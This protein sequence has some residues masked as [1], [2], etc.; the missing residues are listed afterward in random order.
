MSPRLCFP[1]LYVTVIFH[2]SWPSLKRKNTEQSSQTNVFPFIISRPSCKVFF[3][4]DPIKIV[5]AQGQ[6]MFDERGEQYLDCINNVAH[7]TCPVFVVPWRIRLWS[8]ADRAPL[9]FVPGIANGCSS[10]AEWGQSSLPGKVT[11]QHGREGSSTFSFSLF[12]ASASPSLPR[13]LKL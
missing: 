8:K 9:I 12:L 11:E 6:Y 7:G 5:R 1:F 13:N 2:W 4:A 10:L 3:A